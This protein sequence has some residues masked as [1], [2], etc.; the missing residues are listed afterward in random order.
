MESCSKIQALIKIK[1]YHSWHETIYSAQPA[2]E[3]LV[4]NITGS[5]FLLAQLPGYPAARQDNEP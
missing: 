5:Q 2:A 1:K 4:E 3:K